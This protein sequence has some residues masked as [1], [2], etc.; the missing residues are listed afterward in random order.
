ML[1]SCDRIAMRLPGNLVRERLFSV[2]LLHKTDDA[3]QR[4]A[5]EKDAV[6]AAAH[7]RRRIAPRNGAATAAED[8]NVRAARLFQKPDDLAEKLHVPSV[9]AGDADGARFLLHRGAHDVARTAMIA[10]IDDL[11]AML[12]QLEVDRVDGTVVSVADRDGGEDTDRLRHGLPQQSKTI[13]ARCHPVTAGGR[14]VPFFEGRIGS[15]TDS[16]PAIPWQ[17]VQKISSQPS[18]RGRRSH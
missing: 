15:V 9:V 17:T 12:H 11:D 1:G 16:L 4:L 18:F 14:F 10:E 6:H 13:R 5:G 7:H 2:S 3:A 8:A